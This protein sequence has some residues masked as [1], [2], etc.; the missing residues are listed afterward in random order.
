MNSLK[1]N[2]HFHLVRNLIFNL[3]FSKINLRTHTATQN[4]QNGT[5]INLK[6]RCSKIPVN[7][8]WHL[9]YTGQTDLKEDKSKA[10]MIRSY[11]DC[12]TLGINQTSNVN[13]SLYDYLQSIGFK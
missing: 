2:V 12:I 3:I 11:I 13:V 9:R 6:A 10:S 7:Q 1:L 4:T 8:C 5:I